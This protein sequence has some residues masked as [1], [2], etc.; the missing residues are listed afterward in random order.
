MPK[1]SVIL[2][3]YKCKKKVLPTI[4]SILKQTYH[5]FELIIIDDASCDGTSKVIAD[6]DDSRIRLIINEKNIG[7]ASSRN[8][9]LQLASGKYITHC[10]HDDIWNPEKLKIQIA[11]MDANP[12]VG[13]CGTEFNIFV[14]GRFQKTS[15]APSYLSKFL[16]WNLFQDSTFL[17]SSTMVRASVI[18]KHNISY[19]EGL[20]FADDWCIYHQYAKV[21]DIMVLPD[22]L[23]DYHFHGQNWSIK[24]SDEMVRNGYSFLHKEI[25]LLTDCK[26]DK[27]RGKEYFSALVSGSPCMD[28]EKLLKTGEMMHTICESFCKKYNPSKNEVDSI[29]RYISER[30]WRVVTKTANTLGLSVLQIFNAPD[31]P[32]WVKP[33]KLAYLK[34]SLKVLIRKIHYLV[35]KDNELREN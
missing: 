22:A 34:V 15:K 27:Q 25:N 26:Y 5:E 3:A 2:C 6:I 8:K 13:L 11:T 7:V 32:H 19:C 30:W 23:T 1:V 9:G 20:S 16:H 21:S 10:D 33:S 35:R 17:H 29:K 28:S 24:A 18:K 14:N 12:N 4:E 31:T